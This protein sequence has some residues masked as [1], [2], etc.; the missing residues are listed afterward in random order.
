MKGNMKGAG[1]A[2]HLSSRGMT[3]VEVLMSMLVMGIGVLAVVA[4]LPLAFVR[5]VQATNLTNGTI[6]RYNAESQ[7]N[8]GTARTVLPWEPNQ[9]YQLDDA[10]SV[11]SFPQVWMQCTTAGTSA[12]TVPAWNTALGPPGATNA[13]NTCIWTAHDFNELSL[14]Y[15]FPV[16]QPN[17]AYISGAVVLAPS[18]AAGN[19]RR[20]LCTTAGTSGATPP[21]WNTNLTPAPQTTNDGTVVWQTVDHSH[22]V[23]DPTGWNAIGTSLQGALGNNNGTLG[24]NDIANGAAIERFCAGVRTG[25]NDAARLATLPDSW[26]EQARGSVTAGAAPIT[27]VTFN[28]NPPSLTIG[29]SD[30]TWR[31]V[32]ID[33]SGKVSQT[34]I[35]TSITGAT[36]NWSANDPLTGTFAPVQARVEIQEARYTWMLTVLRST[37]GIASVYVTSFFHRPL[38]ANDEQVLQLAPLSANDGVQAPFTFTFPAGYSGPLSFVKKGGFMFDV[39]FGRWYRVSQIVSQSQSQLTLFVDRARPQSDIAISKTFDVVFMR[40]VVDV[41]PIGNE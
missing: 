5:A 40:G 29:P 32:L 33:A 37:S 27:S 8:L 31:V 41:F 1:I 6:L 26:V 11:P 21:A 22:Y 34:R 3:L 12:A 15:V 24:A 14:A 25:S 20:F 17:T 30:P 38:V 28:G 13:D 18:G 2:R 9:S 23:V 19:N 39:T 4:L 16:W 10:V 36:L 7:I 35:L